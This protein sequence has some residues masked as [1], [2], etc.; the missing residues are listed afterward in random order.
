MGVLNLTPDSFYDGG[1]FTDPVTAARRIDALLEEG[2]TL[3][4]IGAESSRP[5]ATP[6]PAREQVVR[7]GAA[8][9]YAV[10]RGAL[11]SVDTTDPEVASYALAQGARVIND[12]SCLADA[13]LA[14]AVARHG[15]QLIITHSRGSMAQMPGFSDWP[16]RDYGD[17]IADVLSEW[18][19]ARDRAVAA[20]VRSDDIM[21]DPGL[22]FSKNAA[23][24]FEI[25]R[26]LGELKSAGARIVLGPGRKS[27][28]SAL[29][30]V[31]PEERLGGTIAACLRAM[32]AGVDIL[33]VHDVRAVRQALAVFRATSGVSTQTEVAR[34]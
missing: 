16:E 30:P 17:I 26:R 27:F 1:R 6:V 11:V 25:L 28:I 15:A 12:V 8:L 32:E 22:G 29:D 34:A 4:D 10:S 31:G 33:R 21:L 7:L 9:G 2:A 20:G 18:S 5:R 3:I 23:H 19:R 14:D 13:K 24:S